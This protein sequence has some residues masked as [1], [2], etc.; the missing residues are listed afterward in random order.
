VRSGE[1]IGVERIGVDS[2]RARRASPGHRRPTP[3]GHHDPA[4]PRLCVSQGSLSH[5]NFRARVPFW[6]R[7]PMEEGISLI[8]VCSLAGQEEADDSY[9][10]EGTGSYEEAGEECFHWGCSL[11]HPKGVRGFFMYSNSS[12]K[13]LVLICSTERVQLGQSST[14]SSGMTALREGFSLR[15]LPAR[16]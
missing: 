8:G 11:L 6:A 13:S 16:P 7:G 1:A 9:G 15:R 4:A 5:T 2:E 3:P 12:D 14:G 10:D